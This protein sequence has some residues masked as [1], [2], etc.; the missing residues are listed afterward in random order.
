L[1]RG[2][3]FNEVLDIV[4]PIC[5][6]C[7]IAYQISGVHVIENALGTRS[8][9]QS[10]HCVGCSIAADGSKA[11]HCILSCCTLRNS[12]AIRMRSQWRGPRGGGR[13]GTGAQKDRQRAAP[14]ARGRE[15]HP[16]N[17]RVGGFYR[18]PSHSE[19]APIAEQL[20][21]ARDQAIATLRWTA[22]FTFPELVRDYEFVALR[23]SAEYPMNAGRIVS[24]AGL[25][26]AV[27]ITKPSSSSVRFHTRR[28]FIL[29]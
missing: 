18:V 4:A 21:R 16:I 24:S 26:I 19:L 27:P 13:A 23:H 1:L 12:W 25:A 8:T 10:A 3:G 6:I 2:L 15:I 9:H 22:Y 17:A 5:G 28:C 7:P 14:P 20:K 29:H 11:M